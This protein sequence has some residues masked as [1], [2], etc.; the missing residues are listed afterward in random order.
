MNICES[1]ETKLLQK[2]H[3]KNKVTENAKNEALQVRK[4]ALESM[5]RQEKRILKKIAIQK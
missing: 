2:T 5:V 3:Y 1:T 4:I